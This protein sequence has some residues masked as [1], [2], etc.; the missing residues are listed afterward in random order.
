MCTST[1]TA[2]N[3]IR[4]PLPFVH[5]THTHSTHTVVLSKAAR[6]E[7]T[8]VQ[9]TLVCCQMCICMCGWGGEKIKSLD[10][11]SSG[12][13]KRSAGPSCCCTAV[14]QNL[15]WGGLKRCLSAIAFGSFSSISSLSPP[16][17]DFCGISILQEEI[18]IL[19]FRLSKAPIV[20][21]RVKTLSEVPRGRGSLAIVPTKTPMTVTSVLLANCVSSSPKFRVSKHLHTNF[22]TFW[23]CCCLNDDLVHSLL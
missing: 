5:D 20:M 8:R 13:W 16:L 2:Q 17:G 3:T 18:N 9:V 19:F 15:F 23:W 6:H 7:Q 10:R 4:F 14:A 1:D 21:A 12:F 11:D 22:V